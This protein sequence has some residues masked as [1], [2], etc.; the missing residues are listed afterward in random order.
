M[1]TIPEHIGWGRLQRGF[2]LVEMLITSAICLMLTTAIV[3]TYIFAL[4]L[5]ET[6]RIKL[7]A[8]DD[9][10]KSLI[11]LVDEV[12]SANK[13]RIGN[14]NYTNFVECATNGLQVGNAIQIY[15]TNSSNIWLQYYYESNQLSTNFSKLVITSYTNVGV[16]TLFTAN[17]ITNTLP[18]FSAEDSYGNPLSNNMNNVVVGVCLQFIQLQYP[19]VNIGA[20]NYFQYYQLHTR[21]TRRITY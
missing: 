13:V 18:L 1:K 3:Y 21:I 10:R 7:S 9:A 20:T 6:D 17:A 8:S 2:T 19:L 14:G 15:P 12:R 16:P 5:H 4:N 11:R